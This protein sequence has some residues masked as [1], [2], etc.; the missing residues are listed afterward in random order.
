VILRKNLNGFVQGIPSK[1]KG[2]YVPF[3]YSFLKSIECR[4][5]V[6]QIERMSEEM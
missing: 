5:A 6:L 2:F 3:D 1:K 4:L